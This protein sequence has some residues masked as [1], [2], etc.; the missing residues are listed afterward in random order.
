[1]NTMV[2]L[3]I[4]VSK[5]KL[6]CTLL[7]DVD[8]LRCRSKSVPNTSE[9]AKALLQWVERHSGCTPEQVRAALEPTGVYHEAAALAL[10]EAGVRVLVVNPGQLRDFAKGHA[11]R[12]KTDAKDSLVLALCAAQV[13][14]TPWQP[15]AAEIRE[16]RALMSRL[17]AVETELRAELNRQEKAQIA[18]DP[19]LVQGSIANAIAFWETE[20]DRLQR[21]IDEHIDRHPGLKSEQA[22]LLSIPAVGEKTANRM[23]C[24]LHE[25][26]FRR[27][28]QLA[29]YLGLV[30][31]E[32]QSGTSIRGRPRL[33]K[34][35]NARMRA[36][37]YMAAVT[38]IRH[39]PD[40]RA[41]YQRLLSRGKAKMSA[42]CAAMRKLVHICFGV[43]KNAQPYRP[44]IE[45]IA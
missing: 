44:Q 12:T 1:M 43:F 29:A 42:L 23:L 16:L 14:L 4:D 24:V 26:R 34:A 40:V 7:L 5:A 9:G 33:S 18:A 36:A 37:L 20:R 35:G 31:V 30:P 3:G 19:Q 38:A 21:A 13:K 11:V 15:A 32:H 27:A 2:E 10:Y 25:G 22:R 17:E 41:L 8:T 6:D 39:N 28:S 45:Q